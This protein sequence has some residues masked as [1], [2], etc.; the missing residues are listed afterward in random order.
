M[1]EIIE[2]KAARLLTT[3]SVWIKWTSPENVCAVVRGD[4]GVYD[5]DLH[6]GRWSCSCEARVECSHL[7]AVMLVTVPVAQSRV[8]VH[9]HINK[10]SVPV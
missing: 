1:R 9:E 7:M 5:V 8:R 10:L 4:T 6:G 3:G 2:D